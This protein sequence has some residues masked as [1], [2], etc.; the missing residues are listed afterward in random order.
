MTDDYSTKCFRCEAS[1]KILLDF[2][3][4]QAT[5]KMCP[6]CLADFGLFIQGHAIDRYVVIQRGHRVRKEAEE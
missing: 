3:I 2:E 4:N 5:I 1:S 6:Q